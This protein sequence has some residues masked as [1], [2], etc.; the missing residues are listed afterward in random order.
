MN[1]RCEYYYKFR[2]EP[3]LQIT[4]RCPKQKDHKSCIINY[5][6]SHRAI[7]MD[8]DRVLSRKIILGGEVS[9]KGCVSCPRGWVW[10]GCVPPP[11]RSA[12]VEPFLITKLI[13]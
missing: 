11:A 9:F 2:Y 10:E 12:E 7:D 6:N 8:M 3:S 13:S 4:G 5:N 1:H